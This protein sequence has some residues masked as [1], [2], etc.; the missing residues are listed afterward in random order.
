MVGTTAVVELS[1]LVSKE[2]GVGDSGPVVAPFI[3][4]MHY[5]T[6]KLVES[7]V[8]ARTYSYLTAGARPQGFD[9][10]LDHQLGDPK[11]PNRQACY[12]LST[13]S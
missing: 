1:L 11:L 13:V 12:A 9:H 10:L 2:L 6:V 3:K 7:S 5:H 4:E 8:V